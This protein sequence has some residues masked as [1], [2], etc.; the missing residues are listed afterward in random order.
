MRSVQKL[1]RLHL[2]PIALTKN[3]VTDS[4]VR[5][6]IFEVGEDIDALM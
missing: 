5:R 1:V 2:R 4:A 3:T 6:L